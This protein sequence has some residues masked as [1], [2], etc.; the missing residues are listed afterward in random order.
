ML[1]LLN[2]LAAMVAVGAVK[3]QQ[4]GSLQPLVQRV[5]AA[6][7]LHKC[8]VGGNV[9]RTVFLSHFKQIARAVAIECSQ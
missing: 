8:K 5:L 9:A 1:E 4:R 2:H 7:G 6:V 3:H